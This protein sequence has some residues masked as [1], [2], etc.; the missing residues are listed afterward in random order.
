[1]TGKLLALALLVVALV[2]GV[3]VA[4]PALDQPDRP[5]SRAP[6]LVGGDEDRERP[7]RKADAEDSDRQQAR[8]ERDDRRRAD[9]PDDRDEDD[10][11]DDVSDSDDDTVQVIRPRP[12]GGEVPDADDDDD[13]DTDDDTDDTDDGDGDD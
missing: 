2:A 10:R 1:M 9:D 7:G 8:D 4:V 6:L 11:D 13:D 3:S 12:G 5:P